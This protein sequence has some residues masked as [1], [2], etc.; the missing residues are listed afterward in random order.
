MPTTAP[1]STP[2]G[3]PTRELTGVP[4]KA[5][6]A[7][8]SGVH[9]GAPS[10]EDTEAPTS[11]MNGDHTER[12]TQKLI[13]T[14]SSDPTNAP[15]VEPTEISFS[16]PSGDATG[17]PTGEPTEAPTSTPSVH[18][19]CVSTRVPLNAPSE[20]PTVE[21]STQPT[22]LPS[23]ESSAQSSSARPT[24]AV[25][26]YLTT[27]PSGE[28]SLLLRIL[29]SGAP[30]LLPLANIS[31]VPSTVPTV[32]PSVG[33]TV[34]LT[35]APTHQ[36]I[37]TPTLQPTVLPNH[38]L[39]KPTAT[40][41]NQ[42]S[43]K[44]TAAPSMQ[45]SMQPSMHPTC[46]P[47][48]GLTFNPTNAPTPLPTYR[49]SQVLSNS[50]GFWMLKSL[51]S[52]WSDYM[53]SVTITADW[54]SIIGG[55]EIGASV[56]EFNAVL[57]KLDMCGDILWSKSYGGPNQDYIRKVFSLAKQRQLL[58]FGEWR[59]PKTLTSDITMGR[60]DELTGS[61][62]SMIAFAG[63]ADC[64]YHCSDA[65]T[66]LDSSGVEV[67]LIV[68]GIS[69][70]AE[71]IGLVAVVET[72]GNVRWARALRSNQVGY[73]I[74]CNAAAR[75]NGG[76]LAVVCSGTSSGRSVGIVARFRGDGVQISINQ[77]VS[78]GSDYAYCITATRDGGYIVVASSKI[79]TT[80]SKLLVV[81]FTNHDKLQ[82]ATSLGGGKKE[83]PR[84]I[85]ATHDG[86]YIIVGT[87]TSYGM[88][89][90][91]GS[92]VR[93]DSTGNVEWVRGFGKVSLAADYLSDVV[94]IPGGGYRIG[95]DGRSYTSGAAS[96]MV[97][98]QLDA[99]GVILGHEATRDLTSAF[100]Y[101]QHVALTVTSVGI[102]TSVI[103]LQP[104]IVT[105]DVSVQ[106]RPTTQTSYANVGNCRQG[107]FLYSDWPTMVPTI[108]PTNAPSSHYSPSTAPTTSYPTTSIPATLLLSDMPSTPPSTTPSSNTP[109]M[110]PSSPTRMPSP[111]P[112]IAAGSPTPLPTYKPSR[113]PSTAPTRFPTRSPTVAPTFKPTH[114]P[115][116][117]PS[118]GSPTCTPSRVPSASPT[119]L[120]TMPPS[121]APSARP[122]KEPT[123]A[124]TTPPTLMP[125]PRL[126][127]SPT[128][129]PYLVPLY[130]TR[131]PTSLASSRSGNNGQGSITE[132][133]LFGTL[134]ITIIVMALSCSYFGV[135]AFF[136]WYLQESEFTYS[137]IY[138]HFKDLRVEARKVRKS[139]QSVYGMVPVIPSRTETSSA[140]RSIKQLFTAVGLRQ[141]VPSNVSSMGNWKKE[142]QVGTMGIAATSS[143][144]SGVNHTVDSRVHPSVAICDTEHNSA[145]SSA[146]GRILSV[147]TQGCTHVV[148]LETLDMIQ[149]RTDIFIDNVSD[150]FFC[151]ICCSL[152]EK[153]CQCK[154]GHV[155]CEQC[156][157]VWLEQHSTC[158]T[159][160]D[161]LLVS[162][163]GRNRSLDAILGSMTVRCIHGSNDGNTFSKGGLSNRAKSCMWTGH[164]NELER[165]LRNDCQYE[166]VICPYYD[167]G[168]K[169]M[170]PRRKMENHKLV[171]ATVCT[172]CLLSFPISQIGVHRDACMIPQPPQSPSYSPLNQQGRG[173]RIMSVK[174]YSHETESSNDSDSES[175]SN[176]G[177]DP[178]EYF[179][180][181][182]DM[183]ADAGCDSGDD[184]TKGVCNVY[185]CSSHDSSDDSSVLP[186]QDVRHDSGNA[187]GNQIIHDSV[188][189]SGCEL[190][191]TTDNNVAPTAEG[192]LN[193][194]VIDIG[195]GDVHSRMSCIVQRREETDDGNLLQ[196]TRSDA[197]LSASAEWSS[198]SS[199]SKEEVTVQWSSDDS[200]GELRTTSAGGTGDDDKY[201]VYTDDDWNLERSS[202]SE[203]E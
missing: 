124:P 136:R 46:K 39:P 146:E 127:D 101:S 195:I 173:K 43:R 66:F 80:V 148:S 78:S 140:K 130:P 90:L 87:T 9:T 44:P 159:C 94:E 8:P 168:C 123:V 165:H 126:S 103:L 29:P 71:A 169:F 202:H 107:E 21:L 27:Q 22:G 47:S 131:D 176:N 193:P 189:V 54:G 108:V 149:T 162:T 180:E 76:D 102:L 150:D 70:P 13:S 141:T 37:F 65:V 143:R 24:G 139:A 192:V 88:G 15:S 155:Y 115:T 32:N 61:L 186:V 14:P 175:D 59:N 81:K 198:E 79:T 64:S 111:L 112:S 98:V 92:I 196:H 58:Y 69:S 82:W 17:L 96:D 85:I 191:N 137:D 91:K 51:G 40:P 184:E 4:T 11:T 203:V 134:A 154:Q 178:L 7:T 20:A 125:V 106:T 55:Y 153:T 25:T 128:G 45:P 53:G 105:P 167:N 62:I 120:P 113:M 182:W 1:T 74:S 135:R 35:I 132:N 118:S 179:Q 200:D 138:Y 201:A 142:K 187:G 160:S 93:L 114:G 163:L 5:F 166:A 3:N 67:A 152:L 99:K 26:A 121:Y 68:G 174:D 151:T 49:P 190:V 41:S 48:T 36:P 30:A 86:G 16:I 60:V 164:R 129:E 6:T 197:S 119:T 177:V 77:F 161:P 56:A 157:H 52:T 188:D 133:K 181:L 199:G 156:I 95:G 28:P 83:S 97:L 31:P 172:E 117:K 57:L 144:A 73:S 104:T 122:S 158:P 75:L 84:R 63:E 23:P 89:T 19:S 171:C 145:R 170:I 10:R 116:A 72:A 147:V 194:T 33:P 100:T 18:P 34:M 2:S 183:D 109:S 110:V 50:G 42:P 12:P 38:P 185:E